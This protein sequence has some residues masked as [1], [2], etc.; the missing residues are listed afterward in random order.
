MKNI[1]LEKGKNDC[2]I[3]IPDD[4]HIVEKTASEELVNYIEKSLSVKLPVVSEKDAN[5]KCIYVGHTGFAKKN[6]IIGKSK[7]NWIIKMADGNLVLTGGVESGDR[8]ILYSVYH[9]LEEYAAVR[10]WSQFEED[11]IELSAISLPDDLYKEGTPAF[12]YRKPLTSTFAGDDG[13]DKYAYLPR[14]RVNVLSPLDDGVKDGAYNPEVRRYGKVITMGRPHHCHVM[15]KYFPADEYFDEHPDWWAWNEKLGMH[16]RHAHYCFSNEGFFNALVERLLGY[17]KEDVE[18]AEK[19]GVELPYYYSLSLDDIDA[20]YFFCQC[21]ECKKIMEESGPSGYVIRFVNRVA[22]EVK[23]IY[24][25]AK[26]ETLAYVVFAFPP[27]DDTVPDENVVIRL[28]YD[29][30][31]MTH[32]FVYPSNKPYLEK[33]KTWS[34]LCSVNGAE[35]QIWQYMFNIQVNFPLPLV[36]GLKSFIQTYREYGVKGVFIET[37]KVSADC[38]D[39]NTYVLYHL[40]ED[41]DCDVEALVEDFAHRYYG[42]AGKYVK[43]YL[44]ILRDAQERNVIHA[45]CM[46]DDTM[47]NYI[48]ARVAI[49]GTKALDKAFE[50]VGDKEPYRARL[51]WLRKPFDGIVLSR[52]YDFVHQAESYGEVFAPDRKVIKERIVATIEEYDKFLRTLCPFAILQNTPTQDEIEYYK[53]LPDEEEVLDI[54]E[55]FRDI[56]PADIYQF[57]MVDNMKVVDK[58]LRPVYGFYPVEDKDTTV[59]SVLKISYDNCRGKQ[60]EFIMA[61]TSKDAEKK[62]AVSFNLWQDDHPVCGLELYREDFIQGGYN[63]YKVGSLENLKDYPDSSLIV[64]DYAFLSVR[65][66]GI[67]V[68]M[69]MDACEVYISIKP[70]GEMYGGKAGEENALFVDRMIVVRKK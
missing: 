5:G 69:P 20:E 1:F 6:G 45:F 26:F 9:F 38:H 37:E 30:A 70:S 68:T 63:I 43:E 25:W 50:A 52:Y 67:A 7:E 46:C 4:A 65:I 13:V 31:D 24:P 58:R 40:L 54:P 51:N 17:I 57:R 48:D 16:N 41:P 42:P 34:K 19:T 2:L 47:L 39:L 55:C 23:K 21:P 59:K 8:G 18:L 32:G 14:T 44:D 36:Y 12:P 56:D 11:V 35:L 29:R 66:N 33:L 3:V 53:N 64:Y 49:D 22:R 27:K 60:R 15:G 28:A 62:N 61:P 10:W